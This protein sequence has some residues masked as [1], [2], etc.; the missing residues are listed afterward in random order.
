M[1]SGWRERLAEAL[2]PARVELDAPLAP[3]VAYRIGGPADV[4]LRAVSAEELARALAMARADEVPVTILGTG[5]NVLVSDAGIRGL[6]VRLAGELADVHV[7]PSDAG[8]VSLEVGA[9]ALNAQL[10]AL[11]LNTGVAGLEF[12]GTIPGTFGGALIMN[13]GAHGGEIGPFVEEVRLIDADGQIVVRVREACGFAYRTSAFGARELLL[14]ARLTCSVGDTQAARE[15]LKQLRDRRRAT[16]P[17]DWPNA[18]SL[19][20]NPPGHYAGRLIEACGLKGARVGG[21]QISELHANFFLNMGGATAADVCALAERAQ[22]EV[23]AR[24]GVALEWEVRR[25][26]AWASPVSSAPE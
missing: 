11:A 5:S 19:F 9:G 7:G 17:L 22:R 1:R 14:S 24:F 6:V 16:Q 2:G 13:A 23:Q 4:Y 3:R 21:A 25:L 10:V 15:H 18:G 8:R 20:K 12:L 26:G